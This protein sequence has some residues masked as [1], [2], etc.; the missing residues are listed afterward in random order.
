MLLESLSDEWIL[1]LKNGKLLIPA[2]VEARQ[3]LR[4]A[5]TVQAIWED[6]IAAAIEYANRKHILPPKMPAD[7]AVLHSSVFDLFRGMRDD[8]FPAFRTLIDTH[9]EVRLLAA[10]IVGEAEDGDTIEVLRIH[11]ELLRARLNETIDRGSEQLEQLP[12]GLAQAILEVLRMPET[13]HLFHKKHQRLTAKRRNAKEHD[14]AIRVAKEL[15]GH[16]PTLQIWEVADEIV[17]RITVRFRK[18]FKRETVKK[19]LNAANGHDG[20][21]IPTGAQRRI[22]RRRAQRHR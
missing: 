19:W 9:G 5:A 2:V 11:P 20:F 7:G 4:D 6:F 3:E 22:S 17:R 1:S 14:E 18:T 21:V 13:V 8:A 12:R 16:S 10:L 15:W